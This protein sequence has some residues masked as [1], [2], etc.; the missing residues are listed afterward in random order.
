MRMPLCVALLIIS[1]LL[2]SVSGSAIAAPGR[3]DAYTLNPG[4]TIEIFVLGD[5]DLS[6]SVTIKPDGM[7]ALPLV[8]EIKASGRTTSQLAAQ[9]V[10]LYQKYLKA[11]SITVTVREFGGRI[12]ILGQVSRPG[13][14]Q[15]RSG[16]GIFELLAS[17]GGPTNRADLAKAT[18]IRDKSEAIQLNL[19]EALSKNTS[20]DVKLKPG[21]VLF[22]PE[23]DP[24]V[25]VLGQVNRPGA[26]DVVAGQRISE[27]V[28]AAGGVTPRAAL[29][30]AFV[31]RG[32]EQFAV[33]LKQILAGNLEANVGLQPRDTLIVPE[34]QD[35]VAVWG[36]VFKPGVYEFTEG[37]KVI[38]AIATAGGQIESANLND[39][40]IIRIEAGKTTRFT[41]NV[42]K[43]LVGEDLSQNILLR[44]GDIVFVPPSTWTLGAWT[45]IV[46]FVK[47][48]FGWFLKF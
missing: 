43:A 19:I 34:S 4:D 7:I 21:D 3:N 31:M 37:L 38:E 18:I 29:Q 44:P 8:G 16:G 13:E 28:A 9:L 41:V 1:S 23:T 40:Y 47:T 14:Y 48:I 2:L 24:R 12:Y 6:R 15:L 33:D 46:A 11:P 39:V 17:A 5:T 25:T 30:K 27:L 20:P 32:S 42:N 35:R 45:D 22:L 36:G 26:Y 10:N